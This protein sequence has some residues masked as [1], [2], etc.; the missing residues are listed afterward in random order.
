MSYSINSI[1]WRHIFHLLAGVSDYAEIVEEDSDYSNPTNR[2]YVLDRESI[3]LEDILG[4]GQFGD[5][6]RGVY[7]DATGAHHDVAIKTC[8]VAENEDTRQLETRAEKFLEEACK[9]S[10]L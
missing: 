8:K 7:V 3:T 2:D 9:S 1:C 6:H 5:V 4:E 10:N